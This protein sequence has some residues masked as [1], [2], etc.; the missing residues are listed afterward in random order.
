[1][2]AGDVALLVVGAAAIFYFGWRFG[3]LRGRN[4]LRMDII[5]KTQKSGG[6]EVARFVSNL[7]LATRDRGLL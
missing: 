7:L 5:E 1:M 2:N 6:E 4:L 3:W